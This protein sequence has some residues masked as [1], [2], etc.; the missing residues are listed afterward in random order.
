MLALSICSVF[1]MIRTDSE[2]VKDR[3]VTDGNFLTGDY[4]R[5]M[6]SY[7]IE[8]YLLPKTGEVEVNLCK[9]GLSEVYIIDSTGQTI[10]YSYV[11]T[12]LPT[13]VYLSTNGPGLYCLVIISNIYYAEGYFTL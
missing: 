3:I 5:S 11:N 13:T 4:E 6:H 9:V 8:A 7:E 2:E 12:D 10:D 1:G